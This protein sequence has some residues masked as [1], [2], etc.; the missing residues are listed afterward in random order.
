MEPRRFTK[1]AAG[2]FFHY[3]QSLA[4]RN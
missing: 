2:K 1:I 3:Y 4:D